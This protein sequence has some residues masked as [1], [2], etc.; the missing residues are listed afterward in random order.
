MAKRS[1]AYTAELSNLLSDLLR[2]LRCGIRKSPPLFVV[3]IKNDF[4]PLADFLQV[5]MTGIAG[6]N[7]AYV[8]LGA[9]PEIG[10]II[11]FADDLPAINKGIAALRE[12]TPAVFK[13][14]DLLRSPA[15]ARGAAVGPPPT[16]I[17]PRTTN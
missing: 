9:G 6:P 2:Q 11:A 10:D 17:C 8:R 1:A 7:R 5:L 12:V 16:W 14:I 15:K 13:L 3:E 4:S